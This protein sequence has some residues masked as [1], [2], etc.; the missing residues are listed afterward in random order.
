M[1]LTPN[2]G[3]DEAS[4]LAAASVPTP[5]RGIQI[6][7]VIR[8]ARR[9][10]L[11]AAVMT[12]VAL[13]AMWMSLPSRALMWRISHEAQKQGMVLSME[14]VN[15]TPWGTATIKDFTWSFPPTR[16][17]EMSNPMVVDEMSIDIAVL[18]LLF[19]DE[20]EVEIEGE[21]DDGH[22]SGMFSQAE[23]QSSLHAKVEDLPL[24]MV[25]K[26]QQALNAPV[27]GIFD[28]EADLVLP[29][30]K[31]E[32]A[33]GYVDIACINCVVGDGDT[34]LYIPGVSTGMLAKGVTTPP[35][36]FGSLQG[37]IEVKD[38]V[39]VAEEFMTQSED[40]TVKVSGGF[41]LKDPVKKSRLNMVI[42]IFVSEALQQSDDNIHLLI[43]TASPKTKMDPPEV[44]WLGFK[45]RGSIGR[46]RF[47][48]IKS[49]T[50]EERLR[51]NR[52]KRRERE[53][54]RAKKRA[55]RKSKKKKPKKKPKPKPKVT[56][57]PGDSPESSSATIPREA[58][59]SGPRPEIVTE[60]APVGEGVAGAPAEEEEEES[61]EEGEEEEESA[62]EGAEEEE[63]GEAESE[64]QGSEAS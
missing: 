48:G 20:F 4:V 56:E 2:T 28:F 13:G 43:N 41:E 53:R 58:G 7:G 24:H 46:P 60:T 49:L 18:K 47:M 8:K 61:A 32:K 25:P 59:A 10:S 29:E 17:D 15:L 23:E 33:N 52:E 63:G 9:I 11:Y 12:V 62:E 27:D 14:D 5:R 22:F 26:L 42:K 36:D 1:D 44:G 16:A 6:G 57:N 45:L 64:A 19:F 54:L 30:N 40:I 38:G 55:E 35:I 21:M 39:G 51:T 50:K 3:T 34:K 31:F 37:R